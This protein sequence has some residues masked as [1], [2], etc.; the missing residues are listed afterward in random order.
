MIDSNFYILRTARLKPREKARRLK[1]LE[2]TLA[3]LAQY[4]KVCKPLKRPIIFRLMVNYE[5]LL[6][7]KGE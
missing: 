2:N 3:A 4:H 7:S 1:H 6:N 5:T